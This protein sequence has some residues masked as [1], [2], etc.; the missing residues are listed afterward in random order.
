MSDENKKEIE[1]PIQHPLEDVFDIESGTT[2]VPKTVVQSDLVPYEG[3]DNKEEEIDEQYQNIHDLALT[4]FEEQSEEA[5]IVDP[6]YKARNAEVAVQYLNT[7]LSA[8]N[9][10]A[11][12]KNAKDKLEVS[13]ARIGADAGAAA[14]QMDRNEILRMFAEQK[15]EKDVTNTYDAEDIDAE[16]G[17]VTDVDE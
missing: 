12:L 9:A 1:V 8:V 17:D 7:A 6:K 14:A 13:K 3:Y 5:E 10:K 4:A 16:D 15:E 11:A 2:M